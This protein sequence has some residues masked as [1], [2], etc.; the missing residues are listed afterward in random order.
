MLVLVIHVEEN[1]ILLYDKN[2]TA[3]TQ[4]RI[5]FFCIQL[6]ECLANPV[7]HI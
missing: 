7:D 1:T 3:E 4:D 6:S 5:Q 2:F